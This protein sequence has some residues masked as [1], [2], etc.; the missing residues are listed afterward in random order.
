MPEVLLQVFLLHNVPG[1]LHKKRSS[2]CSQNSI[3]TM[4]VRLFELKQELLITGDFFGRFWL[5]HTPEMQ[6]SFTN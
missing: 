6:F 5:E 3:C 4:P 1:W 2:I